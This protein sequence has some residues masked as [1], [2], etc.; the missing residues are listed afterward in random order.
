[1][2]KLSKVLKKMPYSSQFLLRKHD[3]ARHVQ[4]F[5]QPK[6]P[7]QIHHKRPKTRESPNMYDINDKTFDPFKESQYHPDSRPKPNYYKS[8]EELPLPDTENKEND[9]PYTYIPSNRHL[10]EIGP[11]HPNKTTVSSNSRNTNP[12][13]SLKYKNKDIDWSMTAIYYEYMKKGTNKFNIDQN[14]ALFEEEEVYRIFDMIKNRHS[15]QKSSKLIEPFFFKAIDTLGEILSS[16]GLNH[17]YRAIQ[18][19]YTTVDVQNTLKLMLR[20]QALFQARY[21]LFQIFHDINLF[22]V[23][24]TY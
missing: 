23:I 16:F 12:Q 7:F 15:H 1:M 22:K 9:N 17:I 13:D 11:K 4:L 21:L 10:S 24:K 19:M 5:N 20:I 2:I 8:M 6:T 18:E 14:Q 3:E